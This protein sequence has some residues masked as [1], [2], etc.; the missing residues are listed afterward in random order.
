[1]MVTIR[2]MIR[3]MN[4]VMPTVLLMLPLSV[5]SAAEAQERATRP[6]IVFIYADD[7][8][9]GDLACHGHPH[10]KTPN[11][12]GSRRGDRFLEFHGGEPRLLA[13]SNR[14]HDRSVSFAL[15]SASALCGA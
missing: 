7:I 10:I 15:G 1:M 8:G 14:D 2:L 5:F 9:F 12:I 4:H 13:Q 6:N 11:L 3:T